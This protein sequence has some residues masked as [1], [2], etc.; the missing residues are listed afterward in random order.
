MITI[1]EQLHKK[2]MVH[3]RETPNIKENFKLIDGLIENLICLDISKN[4][5]L[6]I[7][8]L[9]L[10][11]DILKENNLKYIPTDVLRNNL[12]NL[13]LFIFLV[14][15]IEKEDSEQLQSLFENTYVKTLENINYFNDLKDKRVKNEKNNF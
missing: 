15:K 8:G 10:L 14:L 3:L 12:I 13:N 4:Y 2:V 5:K 9:I 7:H 11:L 1:T 6:H